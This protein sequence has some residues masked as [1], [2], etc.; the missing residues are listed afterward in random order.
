MNEAFE[1]PDS[2]SVAFGLVVESLDAAGLSSE[3]HV[4]ADVPAGDMDP[5]GE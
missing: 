4:R 2:A 5:V 1:Y 3:P